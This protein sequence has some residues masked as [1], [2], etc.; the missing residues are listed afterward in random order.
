M[1]VPLSAACWSRAATLTA[2]PVTMR[3]RP[4][5]VV[6]VGGGYAEDGHPRVADELLD[7]A[8]LAPDLF[9]HSLEVIAHERP[10]VFWVHLLGARGRA[11]DV[12]EE[13]G[14][15]LERIGRPARGDGGAARRAEASAGGQVDSTRRARGGEGSAAAAAEAGARGVLGATGGAS[16]H[17]TSIG[18][19]LHEQAVPSA[20]R[21]LRASRGRR[22]ALGDRGRQRR[23]STDYAWAFNHRARQCPRQESN[24]RTRFRKPLLYPLSYGGAR[25]R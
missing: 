15:E 19:F 1:I 5:G 22:R 7:R 17:G 3:S 25:S 14:D 16:A 21:K 2:S 10:H 8:A 12:G 20:L 4:G 23:R 13:N 24:L 9:R 18:R 11:H 6:L